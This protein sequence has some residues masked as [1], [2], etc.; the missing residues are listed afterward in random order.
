MINWFIDEHIAVALDT[1][2]E[3]AIA[4]ND[5]DPPCVRQEELLNLLLENTDRDAEVSTNFLYIY[6]Y[7]TLY[8]IWVRHFNPATL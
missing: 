2:A 3:S 4:Q 7:Q 1:P 5:T 6:K 8:S